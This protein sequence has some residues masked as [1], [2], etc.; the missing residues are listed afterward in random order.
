MK[1]LNFVRPENGLTEDPLYYMNFEKY[2]D[3]GRDCYLFMADF[4]R[5]LYSGNYDNKEKVA[6]TLEEPNFCIADGDNV[7]LHEKANT[8]LTL[9]PYTAELFDNRTFVFFPFSE[10]WIPPQMEKNI[11]VSYF[12]SFPQALPWQS[13]IQNVFTKYNFRFGHYSMGNVPRCSYQDKILMLAS[14]KVAV[15]HG[16]CSPNPNDAERYRS[17]PKGK[18]NKAF[19]HLD[20]GLMPQIK[21]RMFEAAF[22]KCV[23]L[24]QKDPWN[25]IE[26][27]F[28]PN[29][30]FMYFDDEVDLDKKLEHII[31]HYDEFDY[32][33]ENA[34]N[35]AISNY[36]TKHFVKNYLI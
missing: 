13:Y 25:P 3:V 9:C 36:T 11:D 34:Y 16:L 2:E 4:Y 1:V 24:C 20:K 5:D 22:S 32:M 19:S 30:D 28:T 10:D 33:R 12:G 29:E 14:S 31:N 6:L 7:L 15:V 26:Y 8:I 35:K 21:S 17:F 18:E 23:I 27:F